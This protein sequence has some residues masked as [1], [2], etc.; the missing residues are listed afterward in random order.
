MGQI[1]TGKFDDKQD[2]SNIIIFVVIAA[3]IIAVAC[4]EKCSVEIRINET[5]D[6]MR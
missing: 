3:A 2:R 5:K 1:D 4:L 6:V